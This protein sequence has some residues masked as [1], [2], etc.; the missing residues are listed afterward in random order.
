MS[1]DLDL[2]SSGSS[3]S[4]VKESFPE[5]PETQKYVFKIVSDVGEDVKFKYKLQQGRGLPLKVTLQGKHECKFQVLCVLELFGWINHLGH[6]VEFS[7]E[8]VPSLQG[9][10]E[11][12]EK[13]GIWVFKRKVL[14]DLTGVFVVGFLIYVVANPFIFSQ[15]KNSPKEI[16]LQAEPPLHWD[17][18]LQTS[19]L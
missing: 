2:D 12:K 10:P 8:L 1:P 18:P 16:S 17:P 3:I 19:L 5:V 4:S 13:D 6:N 7:C 15:I 11:G 14:K 9:L